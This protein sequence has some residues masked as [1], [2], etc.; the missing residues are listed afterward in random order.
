MADLLHET[1]EAS[2]GTLLHDALRM[3]DQDF[4]TIAAAE[5]LADGTTVTVA[6]LRGEELTVGNIGD[7]AAVLVVQGE[8]AWR[9]EPLNRLHTAR[10]AAERSR[11]EQTVHRGTAGFVE[12]GSVWRVQGQLAVSRAIGDLALKPFVISEPEIN[13]I[14]LNCSCVLGVVASDGLWDVVT[15]EGAHSCE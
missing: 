1:E 2:I 6:V 8:A 4:T 14:A 15:P 13:T 7:S 10:D 3:V 11:I 9:A 5:Q 12:E